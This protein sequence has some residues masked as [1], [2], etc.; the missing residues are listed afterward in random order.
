MPADEEPPLIFGRPSLEDPEIQEIAACLA[1][2]WIGTGP[3]VEAFERAFAAYKG[4]DAAV[5]VSSCT[6]ALHLSI[7][8]AGIGPGDEVVTS[9]MTFCATVNAIVNAGA[10]PVIADVDPAN[11]C[12]DLASVEARITERTRALLVVHYAGHPC[13]MTRLME[14]ARAR[15][16]VV[17]EDCAH[18]IE[19]EWRGAKAGTVGDF[20]CFSF[21]ATKNVTTGD[22]GM[23]LARDPERLE[24]VRRL[25]LHGLEAGAW[26][27][28]RDGEHRHYL[29]HGPGYK[30]TMT[31][32]QASIGIH[33]LA[34][35][36][37]NA[38]RRRAAWERYLEGTRRLGVELPAVCPADSR[39]SHHLFPVGVDRRDDVI[40]AM[41]SHGVHVGVHYLAI[42][43]HPHY[44]ERFG[45][46][47]EDTPAATRMGRRTLSMPLSP[48][49]TEADVDRALAA[50]AAAFRSTP[51]G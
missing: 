33:Q 7:L 6:A 11:G 30:C 36:E 4:V 17:I 39:H 25:A 2:G 48:S 49:M 35:V 22:G 38:V 12:V 29:V 10:T 19:T 34:R 50:L 20:G 8:A 45:W 41:A 26:Q 31:D 43:E 44:Q 23:V 27:R 15:G 9:A 24:R 32:L 28:F 37:A 1:S 18:A 16:L 13:D 3:R 51:A 5:A 46:R 40:E 21:H 42:P 14:L 47:P